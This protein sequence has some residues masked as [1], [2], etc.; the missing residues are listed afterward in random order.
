MKEINRTQNLG[1]DP[2]SLKLEYAPNNIART[3]M[4][5]YQTMPIPCYFCSVNN[6]INMLPNLIENPNDEGTRLNIIQPYYYPV[7][8]QFPPGLMNPGNIDHKTS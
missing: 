3:N 6:V 1:N 2:N 5:S 7:P 8:F 4:T